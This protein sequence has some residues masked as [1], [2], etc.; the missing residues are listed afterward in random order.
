MGFPDSEIC[1]AAMHLA[2]DVPPALIATHCVRS[3]VDYDDEVVF[4]S[5]VLHGLGATDY[6]GGDQR[7]DVDGA[8]A[9]VNF[10]RRQGLSEDR[11]STV[12]Q[13]IALHTSVGL[14]N[15]FGPEQSV[16]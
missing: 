3:D 5:C 15:R 2:L 7:F 13:S 10:L 11:A 6:D 8:D 9:A 12:W 4:L 16:S 1:S 14:A